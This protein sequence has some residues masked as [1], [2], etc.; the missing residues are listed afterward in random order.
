M[1]HRSQDY[2]RLLPALFVACCTALL[3]G[4]CNSDTRM[5][6]L[7][8]KG[9]V[10]DAQYDLFMV[11]V[12][13]TLFIF[14]AVG[15]AL[16]WAIVRFRERKN[17]TRPPPSQGHGNPLV[18]VSLIGASVLLLVITAVPT[19]RAIWYTH[20]LP[21]DPA[22]ALGNWY[23]GEEVVEEE[24]ENVLTIEVGGYQWWWSF[25]YPQLGV[26]TANELLI[27]AGKKVR[28]KLRS[29]DVIHSFWLP[30]IAGKV[31]L[32]PG[33]TNAMWIQAGDSF[34]AWKAENAPDEEVPESELRAA[35]KD[36]LQEDIHGHYYGQCAEFCGE[37]HARMLFRATV[38]SDAAFA[39]WVADHKEGHTAPDN[40][41]WEAWYETNEEAPEELSGDV[42]EGLKLFV[43][44]G[45]CVT[46]H[47][48]KGNPRAVG[49]TGPDLTNVAQRSSVAA[50]W[51][52][53]RAE[54]GS[55]DREKQY[56]NFYRWIHE[57][58]EIKPG[59]LMWKDAG[60]GIGELDDP[61]TEEEAR[62]LASYLQTLK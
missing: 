42:H 57:S 34:E 40:M 28:L 25:E 4:G 30:R 62:K 48:V 10:A 5:S 8:T 51:L 50:G 29:F 54:D 16:V 38:V 21:D 61:L 19:L 45:R 14:I 39:E 53:H 55:I 18:E 6:T 44:R 33:R 49:T 60:G 59:N 58:N 36:Y 32:I 43:G 41:S 24:E 27:P 26:T 23:P 3:L 1:K 2:R 9:P 12:W 31:D 11:T 20:D 37:S 52:D 13:V 17:D 47:T 22:S 56:E 15:G 46:C 35:Y 7:D